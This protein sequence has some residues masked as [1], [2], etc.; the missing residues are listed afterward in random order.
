[1]M[2]WIMTA[3]VML[4]W[5]CIALSDILVDQMPADGLHFGDGLSGRVSGYNN[6]SMMN[7]GRH[8][9]QADDFLLEGDNPWQIDSLSFVCGVQLNADVQSM[10]VSVY[11]GGDSPAAQGSHIWQYEE[12]PLNQDSKFQI[13]SQ[14]INDTTDTYELAVTLDLSG[15]GA[16]ILNSQRQYYLSIEADCLNTDDIYEGYDTYYQRFYWAISNTSGQSWGTAKYDGQWQ[17]WQLYGG[18]FAWAMEGH[19]I[20]EPAT[21]LLLGLGAAILKKGRRK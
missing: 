18:D 10:R 5:P 8:F 1:M 13:S 21:L 4:I 7:P 15:I 20:P 11:E 9:S 2:K 6:G 3:L 12:M 19:E 17:D 14:L 16:L